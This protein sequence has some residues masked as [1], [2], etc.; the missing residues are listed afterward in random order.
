[1]VQVINNFNKSN[2]DGV[3]GTESTWND[4]FDLFEI[5]IEVI[6]SA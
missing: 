4:S 6:E 2:F 3:T 5:T 1:M